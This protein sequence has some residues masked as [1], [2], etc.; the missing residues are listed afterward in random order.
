MDDRRFDELARRLGGSRRH[1]LQ[2]LLGVGGAVA[3]GGL[4]TDDVEAARR[5]YSGP[6]IS[7]PSTTPNITIVF[8]ASPGG[9]IPHARLAAFPG[10]TQTQAAWYVS[11]GSSTLGP[12]YGLAITDANGF[13]D[14]SFPQPPIVPGPD[15]SVRVE[16]TG[17]SASAPVSCS[18]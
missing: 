13:G 2:Q 8:N 5:G 14:A 11:N 15:V 16:V 12:Y 3:L 17:V 9:C 7:A 18:S 6:R 10:H 4:V 1:F